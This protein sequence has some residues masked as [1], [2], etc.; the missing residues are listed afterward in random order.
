MTFIYRFESEL[1]P[2]IPL[3]LKIEVNTREHFVLLG[4]VMKRFNVESRWFGGTALIRSFA[5]EELLATKLR[6]LYQRRKGRDLF[7]LGI[8]LRQGAIES[9]TLV[10]CFE[11]YME[12]GGGAV[13]RAQFEENLT[14]KLAMADFAADL[15]LILSG[16][17]LA[18]FDRQ[19]TGALVLRELIARLKGDAWRGQV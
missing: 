19:A 13:S 14:K 18:E 4:H 11:E 16:P 7:D 6:A 10:G 15:P 17:A 12:R 5:I 2:V 9:A 3:R 1:P 8:L